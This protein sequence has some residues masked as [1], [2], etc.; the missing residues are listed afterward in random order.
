MGDVEKVEIEYMNT[1]R[2]KLKMYYMIFQNVDFILMP[3]KYM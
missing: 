3:P 2:N 1:K